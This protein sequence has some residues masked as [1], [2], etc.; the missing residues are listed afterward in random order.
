MGMQRIL[1]INM[2][3]FSEWRMEL[4]HYSCAAHPWGWNQEAV[5]PGGTSEGLGPV[6]GETT[7]GPWA[8]FKSLL[9]LSGHWPRHCGLRIQ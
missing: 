7:G 5:E 3:W 1:V 2:W 6:K 8:R 4:R 9:C